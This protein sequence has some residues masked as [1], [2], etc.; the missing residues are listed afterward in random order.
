MGLTPSKGGSRSDHIF[1]GAGF[2]ELRPEFVSIADGMVEVV[3][4]VNLEACEGVLDY[5]DISMKICNNE[6]PFAGLRVYSAVKALS[7]FSTPCDSNV[8]GSSSLAYAAGNAF[9][10]VKTFTRL[11]NVSLNSNSDPSQ[12]SYS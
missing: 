5:R 11:R 3:T 6:R 9:T 1:A 4:L 12:D 7:W 8:Q 2:G 10:M